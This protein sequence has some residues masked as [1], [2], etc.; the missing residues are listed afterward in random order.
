MRLSVSLSVLRSA[1]AALVCVLAAQLAQAAVYVGTWDPKYGPP[2]TGAGP[3]GFPDL[4]WRGSATFNVPA[5]TGCFSN[6]GSLTDCLPAASILGGQVVFY[7][8]SSDGLTVGADFAVVNWTQEALEFFGTGLNGILDDGT[9]PTQFDTEEFPAFLP[10][11]TNFSSDYD[12]IWNSISFRIFSLQFWID[13]TIGETG[14]RFSG[15]VLYWSDTDCDDCNGGRNDILNFPPT[16]F[17]IT[18][19]VPEPTSLALAALALLSV[20]AI[21]RRRMPVSARP[22]DR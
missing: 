9:K 21:T 5:A 17:R 11:R 13:R 2:F 15:P 10:T 14:P 8:V 12:N 1:C 4:G 19:L 20:A 7:A 18:V 22:R 3:A 16:N 6:G